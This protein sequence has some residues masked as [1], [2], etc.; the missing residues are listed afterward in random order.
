MAREGVN[1]A[2]FSYEQKTIDH[3]VRRIIPFHMWATRAIPFYAEQALRHPG[4]A[5]AYYH[6]YQ[7]TKAHAE[8]EGWPAPLR[9]F[10][11]LWEGPGGMMGMFNPLATVGLMD[12]AFESNGG[13]TEENVSAVGSILNRAGE[14]GFSLLPWWAGALN[15]T[16][17]MGD[18][19]LGLDP[20]GTHQARR[21]LGAVVQL[22]AGEGWLGPEDQRLLDKPYEQMWQDVRA[23]LS[24]FLPGSM[25][26]PVADPNAMPARDIRNIMLRNELEARGLT[27]NTYLQLTMEGQQ[28]ATGEAGLLVAEINDA[29]A[30]Q[31]MD[32]GA[33][34][35]RAVRDWSRSN[36]IANVVNAVVPGPKRT[37]QEE[38]LAIQS[39]AGSYFAGEDGHPAVIA[40]VG[41]VPDHDP[42]LQLD[43]RDHEFVR[44]WQERFGAE[45][46]QGDLK[47]MQE[48]A[49]S[50]NTAQNAP[51]ETATILEQQSAYYA[52]GTER[53]RQ[54]IDQYYDI[55]FARADWSLPGQRT[56]KLAKGQGG[57][58]WMSREDLAALDQDVRSDL[59]DA[60][61]REVDTDG[62][63]GHLRELRD[64]YEQT[65]P[66][67]GAYQQWQRDT[68]DQWGTAG[69]FRAAAVRANPN[70]AR[71]ISQETAKLRRSGKS[72]SEISAAIDSDALSLDAFLAYIGLRKN[73]FDP[74]PLPTGAPLPVAS[75]GA[76][77]DALGGGGFGAG[78]S[79]EE[80]VRDAVTET[81]AALVASQEYLGVRLD[82]LPE[83][84]QKGYLASA[85]YPDEARPPS[86]DWIYWDY[87]A[88][89][90]QAMQ[91]GTDGS[92]EAF[93]AA[94]SNDPTATPPQ[95]Q[96][97][98]WPPQPAA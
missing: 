37:R 65:H 10:V 92:L 55:L 26:I 90:Q 16:G 86:D 64:L 52:L 72:A 18:S 23:H 77:E 95:Y 38:G 28:D 15:L 12:F 71:F 69:A 39:L 47:R 81:E 57:P 70:Y 32:G 54:L 58:M 75:E 7:G 19:P 63:L 89:Y 50:A 41:A 98:V 30:A 11:Q 24:G 91:D 87:V 80:R 78:R 85:D 49:L 59:A 21:F 46:R 13:Y 83:P 36:A 35:Q 29:I 88:F 66:E 40:G 33:A 96:S 42:S 45:Y 76:P 22:A 25:E 2:L 51:P 68:R 1:K 97:G 4:F 48:A 84:I 67:F 53:E 9:T 44:R 79:W 82:E 56:R 17:Y 27:L 3:W 31:E 94:T 34:Y 60:W 8:A 14:Y 93:I 61:L 6:T 20:I 5:A 74:M 43:S 62:E 73:R